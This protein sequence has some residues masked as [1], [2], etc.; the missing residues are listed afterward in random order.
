MGYQ[1]ASAYGFTGG[2]ILGT[3]ASTGLDIWAEDRAQSNSRDLM[4][5]QLDL[6][7]DYNTWYAQNYPSLYKQ[8][9]R[10]AGYN[11]ILA[12]ASGFSSPSGGISGGSPSSYNT[13]G[14]SGGFDNTAFQ[15]QKNAIRK[16]KAD[17]ALTESE[18]DATQKSGEAQLKNAE[19]NQ[20]QVYDAKQMGLAGFEI[21]LSPFKAGGNAQFKTIQ[22]IRINKVTGK[23]Y[24]AL[25][26]REVRVLNEVPATS[27]SSVSNSVSNPGSH[28]GDS[29][30][31]KILNTWNFGS[32]LR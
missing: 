10:D 28:R 20:W 11:P 25:T 14:H 8:G 3:A 1:T 13:A 21:Q 6:Q 7:K 18:A 22:S 2:D 9:L 19:T 27:A 12:V 15:M 5:Y 16:Q 26:G 17:I 23:V 24:D 30:T 29:A 32:R 4:R 31:S